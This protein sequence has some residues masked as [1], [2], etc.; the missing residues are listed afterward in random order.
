[1][2]YAGRDELVAALNALIEAER[3]CIRTLRRAATEAGDPSPG[4]TLTDILLDRARWCG[5]LVG[6]VRGL[7]GPAS[8][9]TGAG[10]ARGLATADPEHR[11]AMLARD[12]HRSSGRAARLLPQV[13]DNRLHGCLTAYLAAQE[14]G[15]R[16]I[17]ACLPGRAL[18]PDAPHP[19][20]RKNPCT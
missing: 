20:S 5:I 3:A 10:H 18:L 6:A 19:A 8:T 17:A 13:R 12:M 4:A 14:R 7:G 15:M 11:L 2:G 16:W 1:M 9:A